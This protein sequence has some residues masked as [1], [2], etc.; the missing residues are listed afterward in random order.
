MKFV[1]SFRIIVICL[2]I[3]FLTVIIVPSGY[4][5]SLIFNALNQTTPSSIVIAHS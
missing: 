3:G 4:S 5:Q 2:L 1:S